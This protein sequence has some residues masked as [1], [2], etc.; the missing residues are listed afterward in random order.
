MTELEQAIEIIR[1]AHKALGPDLGGS[2]TDLLCDNMD[3]SVSRAK[4]LANHIEL[5][6]FNTDGVGECPKL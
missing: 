4:E 5:W 2:Y 3:V 6:I 1:K